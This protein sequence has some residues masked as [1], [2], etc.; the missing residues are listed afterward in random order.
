MEV[1]TVARAIAD[2]LSGIVDAIGHVKLP[3]RV[4][5]NELVQVQHL[6]AV[7]HEGVIEAVLRSALADYDPG[8]IN[9]ETPTGRT[10]DHTQILEFS[11]GGDERVQSTVGGVSCAGDLA[12]VV[13]GVGL[14]EGSSQRSELFHLAVLPNEPKETIG[15]PRSSY[16]DPGVIDSVGAVPPLSAECSQANHFAFA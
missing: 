14:A 16:Y 7:V 2:N 9:G 3:S 11:S 10:G 6:P 4:R 15:G 12:F 1:R 5:G 8:V 13:K